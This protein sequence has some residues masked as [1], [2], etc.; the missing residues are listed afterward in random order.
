[1]D[2]VSEAAPPPVPDD[3]L[4]LAEV[5][6][7][8]A[9]VLRGVAL[10]MTRDPGVA[11]DLVQEAFI[12][13][14]RARGAP[15][16]PDELFAYLVRVVLNLTRSHAAKAARRAARRNPHRVEGAA[17]SAGEVGEAGGPGP[18]AEA[19]ARLPRRQREVVFL[20]FWLDL[21][22]DQTARAMGI[23]SGAVKTHSSRAM[24][25]LRDR[26]PEDDD[27]R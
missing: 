18:L 23:S 13:T 5:Y 27:E 19:V 17:G 20:R 9:G 14:L 6:R 10:G 7:D 1:M 2:L 22:V 4:V 15:A 16:D 26:L 12:R 3:H 11:D 8:K 25:T 21:S 24:D